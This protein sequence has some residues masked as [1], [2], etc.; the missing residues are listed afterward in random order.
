MSS[1]WLNL[2]WWPLI[3]SDKKGLAQ[4]TE[5]IRPLNSK[6]GQYYIMTN[7]YL[8]WNTRVIHWTVMAKSS[9]TI[10]QNF[11]QIFAN[12]DKFRILGNTDATNF[13]V[14][15]I[16]DPQHR[17]CIEGYE[18]SF[19]ASESLQVTISF[20]YTPKSTWYDSSEDKCN[21]NCCLGAQWSTQVVKRMKMKP[22]WER[23]WCTT[24]PM[25]S[26]CE[27]SF[28]SSSGRSRQLPRLRCDPPMKYDFCPL[29]DKKEQIIW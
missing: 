4:A 19:V 28:R 20:C 6:L 18:A 16:N 3:T 7:L 21:W 17:F 10:Y 15:N 8:R 14:K 13:V 27:S 25:R 9:N 23:L 5:S 12:S 24:R 29:S 22:G 1:C 2:S 11:L 26:V